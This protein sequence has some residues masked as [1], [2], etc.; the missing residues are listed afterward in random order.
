M[1]KDKSP[2]E[3]FKEESINYVRSLLGDVV[4]DTL[5]KYYEAKYPDALE[6]V[7][8]KIFN[9]VFGELA[10]EKIRH[11]KKLKQKYGL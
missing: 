10:E 9:D 7:I 3:L 4:A 6:R 1:E 8:K 11:I 2:R 5:N